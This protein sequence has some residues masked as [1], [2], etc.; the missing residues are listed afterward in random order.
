MAKKISNLLKK[1]ALGGLSGIIALAP[2]FSGCSKEY[3]GADKCQTYAAKYGEKE[4]QRMK[5]LYD[6]IDMNK[7]S[8]DERKLL[9][10]EYKNE[11]IKSMQ[12]S[13]DNEEIFEGIKCLTGKTKI[14]DKYLVFIS[15]TQEKTESGISPLM[16]Y[17]R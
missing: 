1:M 5:E 9:G 17:N 4:F 11:M 15:R 3:S 6:S 8:E 12:E 2:V 10:W 14:D 16:F 13:P 7:L